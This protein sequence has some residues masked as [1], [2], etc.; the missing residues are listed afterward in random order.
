MLLRSIYECNAGRRINSDR[1]NGLRW[2]KFLYACCITSGVFYVTIFVSI[3]EKMDLYLDSMPPLST[4][5][6]LVH[7]HDR[8]QSPD[9]SCNPLPHQPHETVETFQNYLLYGNLTQLSKVTGDLD[10]P[11]AI[12]K[13]DMRKGSG[14]MIHF[15]H[16]MQ[17][18]YA[19]FS[20]WMEH[21]SKIP[22]IYP[23]GI[24]KA[25]LARRHEIYPFLRGFMELLESQMRVLIYD[26]SDIADW[27]WER[28]YTTI[29]ES[30]VDEKNISRS[31]SEKRVVPVNPK[32]VEIHRPL[33]Y[34]FS[35]ARKLN[36]MAKQ[37][38]S[39]GGNAGQ[40]IAN[41]RSQPK[42]GI[43]NRRPS[44]GRSISNINDLVQ[45]IESEIAKAKDENGN[46]TLTP[47]AQV[48]PFVSVEYFEGKNTLE[49]QIRFFNSIDILV[50]PHG[51]QLTGIPF[52]ANKNCAQLIEYFPDRYYMP[53]FYGSLAIDSGIGYSHVYFSNETVELQSRKHPTAVFQRI[54]TP[55]I[56]RRTEHR[57]QNL[58]IDPTVMVD[59]I[60]KAIVDWD[61][62]QKDRLPNNI[63]SR[64][65]EP[66]PKLIE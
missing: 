57:A 28:N 44:S 49:E 2:I 39:I 17:H 61:K 22:V 27:L 4:F 25:R 55:N 60:A 64:R 11:L 54:V 62:C 20:Y 24:G 48:S 66:K 16:V 14:W 50:S 31:M 33:G 36:E 23:V 6:P 32:M 26:E 3:T 58:C 5:E 56:E 53:D 9:E 40:S 1:P 41:N 65:A 29:I 47:F 10:T 8:E 7:H 35:H 21:P 42:I 34:V 12:C 37:H 52:L 13:L 30:A 15:P 63:H 43:L 19:C 38:Y 59:T 46:V 51:A 18:F 45:S